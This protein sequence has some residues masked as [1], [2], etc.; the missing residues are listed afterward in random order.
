MSG[1]SAAAPGNTACMLRSDQP[2][3]EQTELNAAV[4]DKIVKAKRE[5]DE[6]KSE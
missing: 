5:V 4:R 2:L 6:M 3:R 1:G